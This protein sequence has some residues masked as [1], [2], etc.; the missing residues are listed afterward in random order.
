[1]ILVPFLEF[2]QELGPAVGQVNLL[3]VDED[4]FDVRLSST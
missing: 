1:M 4:L 3:S 2:V